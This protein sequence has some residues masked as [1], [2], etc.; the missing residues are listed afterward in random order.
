MTADTE[1]KEGFEW[2][3]TRA[4]KG[5]EGK[6]WTIL[7]CYK[8]EK[9]RPLCKSHLKRCD[10]YTAVSDADL[11]DIMDREKRG[12]VILCPRCKKT[13]TEK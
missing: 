1:N 5:M 12:D 3:R 2:F 8:K 13:Y 6:M 11:K 10:E 9:Q 7:H 4:E